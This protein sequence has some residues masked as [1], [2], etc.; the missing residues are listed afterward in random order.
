MSPSYQHS[1][2][3]VNLIAALKAL[4]QFSVFSELSLDIQGK[5]YVPDICVYAKRA[6]HFGEKDILRMTEMPIVAMEIMSPSQSVQDALTKIETY[7]TV[8]VKS[9]WLVFPTATSL[10]IYTAIDQVQIFKTGDA[11][12][13]VLDIRIPLDVI[14]A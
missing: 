9:C 14:F 11:V 6:V 8:G 10:N 2:V 3:Q 13:P 5:E 12:D 4:P 1:Y 7:L